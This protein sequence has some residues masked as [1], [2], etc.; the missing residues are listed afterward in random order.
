M[1]N[2]DVR[3]KR[4]FRRAMFWTSA[5]VAAT[6]LVVL[7]RR[8]PSPEPEIDVNVTGKVVGKR[9]T[10]AIGGAQILIRI[11]DN[12]GV[13]TR[14][15]NEKG[16]YFAV[17]G[18]QPK[19]QNIEIY[20]RAHG[21]VSGSTREV[22]GQTTVA[23]FTLSPMSDTETSVAVPVTT[24]QFRTGPIPSGFGSAWSPPHRL[25]ADRP[26]LPG[27]RVRDVR[28]ELVGDRSCGAWAECRETLRSETESCFEFRFQGHSEDVFRPIGV[29]EGVLSVVYERTPVGRDAGTVFLTY[30]SEDMTKDVIDVVDNLRRAGNR[31]PDPLLVPGSYRS[32]VR[33]FRE[34][35]AQMAEQV[36]RVIG[37]H[38]SAET[39]TVRL[40]A[41]NVKPIGV[42]EV[43]LA[44]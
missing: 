39:E 11:G 4:A 37:E 34:S 21:F 16:S 13:V 26:P 25:C 12:A 2:G 1:S 27:Y 23:D 22:G 36:R 9:G 20:A 14:Y 17:L 6:S 18:P 35:E 40:P 7:A 19:Q 24:A 32:V 43:W 41:S 29:A 30:A 3:E 15:T 33:V 31:V 28:F 38:F 8:R 5:V 10:D 42:A 44:R